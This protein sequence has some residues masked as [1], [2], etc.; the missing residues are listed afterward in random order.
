MAV[1]LHF[2]ARLTLIGVGLTI[3]AVG[4]AKALKFIERLIETQI[5]IEYR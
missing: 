5:R 4:I 2:K 3:I 1:K